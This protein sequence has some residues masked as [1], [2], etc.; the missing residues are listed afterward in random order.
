MNK[1]TLRLCVL[2]TLMALSTQCQAFIHGIEP[3]HPRWDDGGRIAYF[4]TVHVELSVLPSRFGYVNWRTPYIRLCPG[5]NGRPDYTSCDHHGWSTT[6]I[7]ES[8]GFWD[9][10]CTQHYYNTTLKSDWNGCVNTL[11]KEGAETNAIH[12]RDVYI[13]SYDRQTAG[14][15]VTVCAIIYYGSRESNE[16]ECSTVNIPSRP[17]SCRVSSDRTAIDI[18]H[19][20]VRRNALQ[21]G[22]KKVE[23][24]RLSCSGGADASVVIAPPPNGI[25]LDPSGRAYSK[26]DVGFG[27]GV[28]GTMSI[29]DGTDQT[30]NITV[31]TSGSGVEAGHYQGSGVITISVL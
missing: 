18:I 25:R 22:I 14:G 13:P 17:I 4:S 7:I 26:I 11:A 20:G 27:D 9:R 15:P 8:G 23:Q 6:P 29:P 31:T 24:I 30:V 2:Q 16:Y 21:K 1:E 5:K 28:S 12:V 3:S 10:Y 19:D